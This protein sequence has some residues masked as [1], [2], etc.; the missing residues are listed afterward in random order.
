MR[1]RGIWLLIPVSWAVSCGGRYLE[2]GEAN[3][4]VA[5]TTSASAGSS[6]QSG[7]GNVGSS[8]KG[9]GG[10]AATGGKGG[11]S[12]GSSSVGGGCA[13]G[14][15]GCGPG[16]VAVPSPGECCLHCELDLA[17]CNQGRQDYA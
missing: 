13:C 9:S 10:A 4:D 3:Y 6:S 15:V 7:K 14:P 11:A 2:P 17:K 12:S 5:G 8:G 1:A 16:Y